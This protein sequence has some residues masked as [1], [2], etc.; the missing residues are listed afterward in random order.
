MDMQ[1]I[2][3]VETADRLL[4]TAFRRGRDSA[5]L[6]KQKARGDRFNKQK[7]VELRKFAAARK[8]LVDSLERILKSFPSFDQLSDFY[9]ELVKCTLDYRLLK[10][11][12]GA[13]NW[14]RKQVDE[15]HSVYAKRLKRAKYPDELGKIRGEFYG[16]ISSV[17]KQVKNELAMLEEARKIMRGYPLFKQDMFTVAIAGFPN[18][19][20]TTLLSKLTPA[21]PEIA[22][23]PFTTKGINMGYAKSGS[24]IIQLVDTPGTLNRFD[25][26]NNIEKQAYLVIKHL[27]DAVVYVFDLTEPY[28]LSDQIKLYKNVERLKPGLLIYFSKADILE[29]EV[30]DKFR[31]KYPGFYDPEE[32]K[33][34]LF[35]RT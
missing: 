16:R 11:S 32:L 27:A 35:S 31:E 25:K 18:V 19:G 26:M 4:D 17:L 34:H 1:N 24:R 15:L 7:T 10:K 2:P 14:A 33:N 22:A 20:K 21:K 30:I 8:S 9:K 13:V 6:S 12:L 28:P 29:Q 3:K 23:Y 5:K